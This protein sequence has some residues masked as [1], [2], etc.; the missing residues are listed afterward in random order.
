VVS[1]AYL[2]LGRSVGE[3]LRKVPFLVLVSTA[4]L[5][6]LIVTA[7]FMLLLIP[8]LLCII[9]FVMAPVVVSTEGLNTSNALRRSWDLVR[10]R[11][12]GGLLKS[13]VVRI[14]I[15]WGFIGILN[16]L[17]L[18]MVLSVT[19]AAPESWKTYRTVSSPG[20]RWEVP[21]PSLQ[22]G[23]QV[24]IDIFSEL[25]QAFLRPFGVCALVMLYYDVRLRREGLDIQ[26]LLQPRRN[27]VDDSSPSPGPEDS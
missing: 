15:I 23:P 1:D 5:A 7:G 4:V 21:L 14:S 27:A 24:G 3:S 17:G 16:L 26:W 10:R 13:T 2:R 6:T 11:L 25:I 22:P 9:A 12:P 8:A 20:L 19:R 18:T